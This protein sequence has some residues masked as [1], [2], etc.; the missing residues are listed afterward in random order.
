MN[1]RKPSP[2]SANQITARGVIN[3]KTEKQVIYKLAKLIEDWKN[4]EDFDS[5]LFIETRIVELAWVLSE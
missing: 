2:G 5:K 3:M 1:D 4:E